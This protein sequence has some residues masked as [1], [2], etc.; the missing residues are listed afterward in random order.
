MAV[1]LR[2][3]L[4]RTEERVNWLLEVEELPFT[5]NNHY[6]SDYKSKFLT[7]FRESRESVIN[8]QVANRV[9]AYKEDPTSHTIAT[10]RGAKEPSAMAKVMSSLAEVGITGIRPEDVFKIL[11]ED[12]MAPALN[13]MAD[14]RAY[15]QGTSW[16]QHRISSR[17]RVLNIPFFTYLKQSPTSGM[18]TWCPW[19]LTAV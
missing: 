8:D 19:P 17:L 11:P 5:L 7:Y 12:E 6:L 9:K 13:I 4:Q 15:F 18:W 1:H 14:V 3:C 2:E 16:A 10:Y